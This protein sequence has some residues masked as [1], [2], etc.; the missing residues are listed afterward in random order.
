MVGHSDLPPVPNIVNPTMGNMYTS[1]ES[2][3]LIYKTEMYI[4][5]MHTAITSLVIHIDEWGI[6][7]VVS[8]KKI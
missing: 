8:Y 4:L 1:F 7:E 6:N 5:L 3:V 2:Y